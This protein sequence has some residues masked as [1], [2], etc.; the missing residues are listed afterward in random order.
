MGLRALGLERFLQWVV[1]GSLYGMN[2]APDQLATFFPRVPFWLW[3]DISFKS[4]LILEARYT[5]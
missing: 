2:A 1:E 5:V 4:I 3:Y